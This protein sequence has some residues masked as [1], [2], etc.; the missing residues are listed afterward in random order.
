MLLAI[1]VAINRLNRD[2]IVSDSITSVVPV[3]YVQA[4]SAPHK[5]EVYSHVQQPACIMV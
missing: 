1:D 3:Y 5:A 4:L 2:S